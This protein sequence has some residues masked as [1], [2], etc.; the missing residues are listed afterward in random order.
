MKRNLWSA[1]LALVLCLGLAGTALADDIPL[2]E[3]ASDYTGKNVSENWTY[4][5]NEDGT[6][7]LKLSLVD[8]DTLSA[9]GTLTL[10]SVLDGH[11]VTAVG[12]RAFF[13]HGPGMKAFPKRLVIPEGYTTLER[14]A[15]EGLDIREGV[16]FPSTLTTI[17]PG[18]FF[19]GYFTS[20]DLPALVAEADTPFMRCEKLETVTIRNM[21]L[22]PAK[23]WN[24][25]PRALKTVV[26]L[27]GSAA[28]TFAKENGLAVQYVGEEAPVEPAAP[29][30][31]APAEPAASTAVT[32]N[33]TSASVL[34]NGV[35]TAF[36]AY[37][38]D[39]NNYF[40]L[41]DLA[42]VLSGTEKQFEISWDG[43]ANAISLT[44]GQSY[45]A[46]GGEMAAGTAGSR[47]AAPTSSKI[48]VNGAEVSL[49]AYNIGN[50]NYFKLRDVGQVFDFGIGWDGASQTIS[51]DTGTGYTA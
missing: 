22:N 36:D 48:L 35:S 46:V 3:Y 19:D 2:E 40:K 6:A 16:V 18:A 1:V 4:D 25:T 50:N 38:I 37:S 7:T 31:P 8:N 45:T 27:P 42:Y 39:G 41:R 10:P 13:L 47:S 34:V 49:T 43:A 32:A 44:A 11:T 12:E 30:E 20:I 24:G 33:P 21:D 26:C 9:D 5:I 15:F 17:A 14:S 51:I 28:E 23:L 29:A